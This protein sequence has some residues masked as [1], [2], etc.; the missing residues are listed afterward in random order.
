MPR[1]IRLALPHLIT[2]EGSLWSRDHVF[3]RDTVLT[4][5]TERALGATVYSLS[6]SIAK[7]LLE[8]GGL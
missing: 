5:H 1:R 4:E 8:A 3:L 2:R 6:T 7:R